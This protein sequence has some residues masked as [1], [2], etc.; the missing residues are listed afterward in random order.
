[1]AHLKRSIVG[2]CAVENCPAYALVIALE[3]ETNDPNYLSYV[4][5]YKR[6]LP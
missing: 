2:V 6:I 5:V 3:K 1:M 4:N